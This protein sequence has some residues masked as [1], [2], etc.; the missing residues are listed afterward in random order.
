MK[1]AVHQDARIFHE[2]ESQWNALL[3]RSITDTI[4]LTLEWQSTWWE[5]YQPGELWV[6]TCHDAQDQLVGIAPWFIQ[7]KNGE[8]VV[9]T[10]GCVDVTD[11]VD[12]IVERDYAQAVLSCFSAFLIEHRA[13]Y[14]RINLCNIPESSPTLSHF[15][16]LLQSCGFNVEQVFQEVCP[17]IKLPDSWEGYLESLDKKQRHELRRKLRRAESEV[18]LTYRLIQSESEVQSSLDTFLQLMAASQPSKAQFLQDPQNDAFFRTVVPR[19]AARGWLKLSFLEV[20]GEAVAAYCDFDYNGIILVYNSGLLIERYAHLSTGIVLLCYNIR[21][22]IEHQ[23][24]VFDFLRGNETYK[25]RMG[26]VDTTIYKL[27]AR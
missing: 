6:V 12:V 8:R 10:I 25:Y 2:L 22:A 15:P 11:Y 23:R 1:T 3:H 9:R 24:A 19:M 4:F 5:T 7:T 14:D 21:H 13:Q 17:V 18:Q 27:M 16:K 20:N 26:G